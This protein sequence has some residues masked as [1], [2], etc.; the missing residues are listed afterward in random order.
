M[1]IKPLSKGGRPRG[2]VSF[3]AESATAFGAVVREYRRALG[4]SQETFAHSVDIERTHFSSIERGKNQ[5]SLWLILK[6][7]RGLGISAAALMDGTE[8]LLLEP[9]QGNRLSSTAALPKPKSEVACTSVRTRSE[10]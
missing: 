6:I 10:R 2:R 4:V 1:S 5:P 7:A 9:L 3:N 8:A